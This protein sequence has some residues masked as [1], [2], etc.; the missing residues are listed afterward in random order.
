MTVPAAVSPQRI[1]VAG[2]ASFVLI[3]WASPIVPALVRTLERDFNQSDAGIGI[4]YL[5]QASAF[6]GGSLVGGFAT[7]RFG[8]RPVLV[9]A[10][11]INALGLACQGLAPGWAPFVAASMARSTGTGL[12]EGG[13]QGLFLDV[14]TDAQGRFATTR[15][16]NLLHVAWS[17]GALIAPVAVAI[18]AT[19]VI[20]WRAVFGATSVVA[21]AL[22]VVFV[23]LAMPSGRRHREATERRI[24]FD[25]PLLLASVGIAA[26]VAAESGVAGWM[27]RFLAD[28]PL[29]V[30]SL[31]LTLFWAGLTVG[32]L[33]TARF[34]AA[35]DPVR[36][37][38]VA[39]FVAGASIIAAVAAPAPPLAIAAFAVA[40]FACGPI[41]P[42]IILIG[43]RLYPQRA[44]A[45]TGILS[46]AG[47]VGGLVYPPVVGA[48]S[49]SIGIRAAMLGTAI[50]AAMSGVLALASGR[51]R[52]V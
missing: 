32:R 24:P 31:G 50:L 8:R 21:L 26:Y 14:F 47:V 41:F 49:V 36:L 30:A 37:L 12:I 15:M 1:A 33:A 10:L 3:G 35:I 40:G 29:A 7:E 22:G 18:I 46:A 44:A 48:L 13:V 11:C 23:G 39:S 45:V 52:G 5:L 9:G 4:L 38:V 6:L 19:S 16:M 28:A 20:G 2:W 17:I 34:G 43:G 27:V 51:R 25:I 42:T